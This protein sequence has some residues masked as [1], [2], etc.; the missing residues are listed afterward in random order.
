MLLLAILGAWAQPLPDDTEAPMTEAALKA[1]YVRKAEELH[2]YA[3]R[4]LWPAVER[5]YV[6]CLGLNV[7]LMKQDHIIGAEAARTRGEMHTVRERLLAALAIDA[8][9]RDVIFTLFDLDSKYG[10]VEIT[11]YVGAKL[12]PQKR[13]FDAVQSRA[14]DHAA[15]ALASTGAFKGLLPR[16]DYQVGATTIALWMKPLPPIVVPAPL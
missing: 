15:N 4:Q 3:Q 8:D 10:K 2:R 6:D 14:I 9:D 1:E 12:V 11:A 5:T 13:P 7:L 16:G